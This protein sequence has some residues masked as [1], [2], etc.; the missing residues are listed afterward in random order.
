MWQTD[1]DRQV[2]EVEG[3]RMER[4]DRP[5]CFERARTEPDEA[6]RAVYAFLAEWFSDS[7]FVEVQ[8]SGSTGVP[9]RMQVEKKRMMR[10]AI[11]TCEFL[12]LRSGVT[13]LLCMDLKYIGAK[14]MVVRALVAGLRLRVRRASG[15]PLADVEGRVDFLSVVPMQLYQT[16]TCAEEK[17]RLE[18]VRCVIVGGGAVDEDQRKLLADLPCR[19]YSTYGMTETLSHIALHPLNGPEVSVGYR[20]FKGVGLSLSSRG[21]LVIHAP[22]VCASDLETNDVVRLHA[23]GTFTIVG[24]ADNTVNSG[25][26]K[27]QIEEEEQR[28][29]SFISVPFALTSV[30][31]VRLGEALV[32]VLYEDYPTDDAVLDDILK[33]AL[34]RYHAPRH[35]VRVTAVPTTG[36]G[37]INRKACR[38]LALNLL[39]R[40]GEA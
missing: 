17:K 8:T 32:L 1:I 24:R 14:M 13:A 34:P 21:T 7:P 22:E 12:E 11:R 40:K 19:V 35:I 15:H 39:L 2:I 26:I 27:M 6:L 31:D 25:G 36:N 30:P 33:S 28:I 16:L 10:S 4:A 3:L 20:P 9:K 23:D 38:E 37:K 5:E 18:R 29:K